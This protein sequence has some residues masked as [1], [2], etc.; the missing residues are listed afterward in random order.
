MTSV[1]TIY[2]KS[3]SS[4]ECL[5][6]TAGHGSVG[7]TEQL[8]DHAVADAL[9]ALDHDPLDKSEAHEDDQPLDKVEA[10]PNETLTVEAEQHDPLTT[11]PV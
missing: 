11:K 7:G 2:H 5:C 10:D 3:T 9:E 4:P 1:P 6:H 8:H